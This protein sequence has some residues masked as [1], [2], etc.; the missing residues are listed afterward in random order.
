MD[1]R[2]TYATTGTR[3]TVSERVY[4]SPIWYTP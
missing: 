3:M 2:E 4:A 1:R